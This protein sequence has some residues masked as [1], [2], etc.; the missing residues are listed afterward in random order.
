ME[1][2]ITPEGV[3]CQQMN[4]EIEDNK[5]K[6]AEFIGGCNGNLQGIGQLI[7]GMPVDEVISKLH[8]ILCGGKSTSCPDQLSKGLAEYLVETKMQMSNKA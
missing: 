3:C 5:I 2:I 1:I 4:I 7:K 8:G 6:S